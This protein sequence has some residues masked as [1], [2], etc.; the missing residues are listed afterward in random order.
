MTRSVRVPPCSAPGRSI[1][2]RATRTAATPVAEA[3]VSAH[4]RGAVTAWRQCRASAASLR[5]REACK[6]P[7]TGAAA[8]AISM[9]EFL[10]I[11]AAALIAMPALA[12]GPAGPA[13]PVGPPPVAPAKPPSIPAAP[14]VASTAP[15]IPQMPAVI[16]N[17]P[18]PVTAIPG[19][20]TGTAK[21]NSPADDANSPALKGGSTTPAL[22]APGTGIAANGFTVTV[23]PAPGGGVPSG[24]RR[25]GECGHVDQLSPHPRHATHAQQGSPRRRYRR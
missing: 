20:P 19:A 3:I 4:S 21:T 23:N 8:R 9:H 14:A 16:P 12:A 10:A 5:G 2:R 11:A 6:L 24:Y 15:V 25:P 7:G 18:G 1:A 17:I 22:P 13:G